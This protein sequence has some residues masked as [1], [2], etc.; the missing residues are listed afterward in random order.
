MW[1]PRDGNIRKP[2]IRLSPL[3]GKWFGVMVF[4]WNDKDDKLVNIE[5]WVDLDGLNG[6]AKI[7]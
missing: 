3:K 5:C 1:H 4:R 2:M 7:R 6:M